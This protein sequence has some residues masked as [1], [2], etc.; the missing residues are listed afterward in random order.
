MVRRFGVTLSR[1]ERAGV[2]EREAYRAPLLERLLRHAAMTVPFYRGR[3][4]AVVQNGR[5]DLARWQDLPLLGRREAVAAGAAL[6][7]RSVPPELGPASV[8]RSSGSTGMPF[9]H[10]QDRLARVAAQAHT[11]RSFRWWRIDTRKGLGTLVHRRALAGHDE[12]VFRGWSSRHPDAPQYALSAALPVEAQIDWLRRRRPAYLTTYPST[13]RELASAALAAQAAIRLEIVMSVGMA[14]DDDTRALARSAF[15]AAVLDTYGA[16]EVGHI[17]ASC[18][19]CGRHHLSAESAFFEILDEAGRPVRPGET[20]EVVATPLYS[21]SMPLIRYRLGDFA[22]AAEEGGGA[23]PVTLPSLSRIVG[24]DRSLFRY[25]DGSRSFPM[26]PLK[27]LFAVLPAVQF[28]CV[29]TAPDAVEFRYVAD[30]ERDPGVDAAA[31]GE[32][33]RRHLHPAVSATAVAMVALP[34]S[35]SGKYEDFVSLVAPEA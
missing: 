30:P 6:R 35:A 16:Q 1:T 18:P 33:A 3:L 5:L 31:L 28:Q 2:D 20:G 7:S 29:Q 19:V 25:P 32:L 26:I 24:R 4:G 21:Y 15:G 9:E 14:L 8:D 34:R 10:L 22:V 27:Q 17:S 13:L 23:C 12:A 11:E